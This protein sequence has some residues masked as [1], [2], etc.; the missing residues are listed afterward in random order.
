M[1]RASIRYAKAVLENALASGL[2]ESVNGDMKLVHN[3]IAENRELKNFLH[4]PVIRKEIKLSA[5]SEVFSGVQKDTQDL[6][7]LLFENKR[8][9]I[10]D[11]VAV[12]YT[13]LYDK[14]NG[15]E[16]VSVITALPL[17]PELEAKVLSKAKEFT[18][19]KVILNSRVDS[20]ILGGFILRV[21]DKQYNASVAHKLSELK[22]EFS[23]N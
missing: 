9:E 5:L 21:G 11:E 15:V 12:Q 17:T 19:N 2:A 4:N 23:N 22:R 1:S 3:T 20:S 18:S 16:E 13:K 14:Q 7:K 10:L 8:F 6:F